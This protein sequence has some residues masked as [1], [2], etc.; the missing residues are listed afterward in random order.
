MKSYQKDKTGNDPSLQ[1]EEKSGE[2][3]EGEEG[4]KKKNKDKEEKK[5]SDMT[6]EE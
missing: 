1:I 6:L 2:Q 4:K 5:F 3:S